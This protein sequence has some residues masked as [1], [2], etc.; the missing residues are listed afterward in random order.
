MKKRDNLFAISIEALIELIALGEFEPIKK[1][2]FRYPDQIGAENKIN[3]YFRVKS[4]S[5]TVWLHV[6]NGYGI[7]I[8]E[9]VTTKEGA[10]VN[11]VYE[12]S[13]YYW[14]ID[15]STG[16]IKSSALKSRSIYRCI[17]CVINN[18]DIKMNIERCY[19]IHHKWWKWCNTQVAM[20]L[21][22]KKKH[23]YFHNYIISRRSHQRGVVI[24]SVREFIVWKNVIA[25]ESKKLMKQQM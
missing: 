2:D 3:G 14:F 13:K 17:E 15:N 18:N 8:N 10:I 23:Q 11:L 21:V 20:T 1:V 9:Y 12:L 5:N 6:Q 19:D 25:L 16:I 7:F 4:L 24:T 22:C